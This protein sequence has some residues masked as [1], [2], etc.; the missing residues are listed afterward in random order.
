[1]TAK[2]DVSLDDIG[3]RRSFAEARA[4]G[5]DMRPAYRAMGQASV[6]QTRRRFLNSRAPDGSTWKPSR[7]AS[8][9]TLIGKGLLLRSVSARAPTHDGV[10]VGS[11]RIYA[12]VHQDGAIIRA[13][14]AKGLRFRVGSNGGWVVRRQIEIPARPYLGA[15]DEDK[16][17]FAAI[18]LRHVADPLLRGAL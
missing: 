9:Q 12:G 2:F 16:A 8:G 1:M 15:N 14:T 7:K 6:A 17:E 18:G 3:V 5:Q 4:R 13:K 10:V 11:N